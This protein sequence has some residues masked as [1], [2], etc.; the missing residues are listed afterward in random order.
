MNTEIE[1]AAKSEF[2]ESS[3]VLRQSRNKLLDLH[4]V[5]IDSEKVLIDRREGREMT[6]GE[7]LGRLMSD[8]DLDWLRSISRLVVKVDESFEID[9][10]I[11]PELVNRLLS[12]VRALFDAAE[13]NELFKKR[14]AANIEVLQSAGTLKDEIWELVK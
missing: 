3:R 8:D 5:L 6:P 4:K 13:D 11:P 7:F 1:M 10:G 9:D 2:E 14:L 12:E